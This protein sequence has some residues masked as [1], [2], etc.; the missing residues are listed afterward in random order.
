MRKPH[1]ADGVRYLVTIVFFCSYGPH[2]A[3]DIDAALHSRTPGVPTVVMA[4]QPR[5]A[6]ETLGWSDVRLI[7]AGHTHAGQFFP[8]SVFIYLLNPFFVGLYEP[9][10]GVFVYVSP[11]TVY[12]VIPFRHY[13]PEITHFTLLS[14]E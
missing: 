11:G 14:V 10:P 7:L 5:A 9:Q 12:Y 2:H 13:R 8:F 1:F 3:M 4:H 6:L